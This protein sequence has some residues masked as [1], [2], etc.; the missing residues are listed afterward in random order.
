M[1]G[2]P[3]NGVYFVLDPKTQLVHRAQAWD[4]GG[5]TAATIVH[6]TYCNIEVDATWIWTPHATAV[7]C[8]ECVSTEDA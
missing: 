6:A 4:A 8:L 5:Y 3:I 2:F 7:T 1:S